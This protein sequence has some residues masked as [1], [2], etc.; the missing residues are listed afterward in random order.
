MGDSKM[1]GALAGRVVLEGVPRVGFYFEVNSYPEWQGRTPEDVQFPSCLRAC[2]E[3]LG[4]DFGT[5]AIEARGSTWRLGLGYTYLMGT[6]GCAFRLSW[7][8]GW[9][10]DNSAIENMSDDPEAPYRKAFESVGYG[11][12][13]V[14]REPGRENEGLFRQRIVESI[15]EMQRP[16]L[17]HGVVG[18]PE[19]CI[20]L[21]YDEGG[22][23]LI[24]WSFFQNMPPFNA[25][26]EFEPSGHFR[27]RDWCEDTRSLMLIGAKQ[28]QP[29]RA[30]VYRES[31]AWALEVVRTPSTSG[32]RHNGLAAYVAWADELG[33]DRGFTSRDMEVLRRRFMVHHDAVSTVAEGRWYGAQFLR[34][35][36]EAVPG[37]AGDLEG[38]AACYEAEHHLM[39]KVWN[40]TGG[41]GWSDPQVHRLTDREVRREIIPLI[42]KSRDRD[43]EASDHI[44]K[45]L[46]K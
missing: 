9:H 42:H 46:G 31:L 35:A 11:Y 28:P 12:E 19:D 41:P 17:A 13:I 16:V 38:A 44:E 26:V 40:L 39:W 18:P 37:A 30:E 10:P 4:E 29:S 20:V 33:R 3:Y 7:K 15:S 24:G 36:A 2:L 1:T 34:L 21:G 6:S 8:P 45:A 23:V 25:G 14:R 43:A 5:K 32:D 27:K 22:D